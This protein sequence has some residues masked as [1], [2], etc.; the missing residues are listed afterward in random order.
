MRFR[1]RVLVWS[2]TGALAL[3]SAACQV[4]EFDGDPLEAD[5]LHEGY[6]EPGGA[7]DDGS[8]V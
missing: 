5:P 8:G 2:L 1:G 6:E 4:E 3:A 7:A